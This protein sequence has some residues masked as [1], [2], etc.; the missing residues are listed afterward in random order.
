MIR[1]TVESSNIKALGYDLAAG[2]LEVE[3]RNGG[4]YQYAGVGAELYGN[5]LEADS[6]GRFLNQEI[7]GRFEVEKMPPE[8][9]E[10]DQGQQ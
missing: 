4:I 8:D 1:Q 6:K 9:E 2:I 3:F 7:K 5:L 10:K